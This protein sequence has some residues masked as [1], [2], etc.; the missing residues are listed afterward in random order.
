MALSG[1][2]KMIA[3]LEGKAILHELL[4]RIMVRN[5]AMASQL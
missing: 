4:L 2:G 5:A 1:L 3:N